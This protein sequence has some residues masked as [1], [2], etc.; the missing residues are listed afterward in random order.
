M[1]TQIIEVDKNDNQIG[2]KY[3]DE[4]FGSEFIHRAAHLILFNSKNEILLQ[5]RASTK[6]LYP[7]VFTFSVDATVDDETYEECITREVQEELGIVVDAKRLFTF[8][9][10]DDVDRAWHCVF[11]GASDDDITPDTREI[12]S[13]KWMKSDK[14]KNDI[15]KNPDKYT[16]AFV[17]GMKKYFNEF[18]T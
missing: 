18:D 14:L 10:F 9:L 5:L 6:K 3:K 12:Q 13:I 1:S 8:P 4:F 17:E 7:D 16:P 15:I 11:V 2:L